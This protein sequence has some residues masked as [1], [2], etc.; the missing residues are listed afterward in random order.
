M[1]RPWRVREPNLTGESLVGQISSSLGNLT[2][3]NTLDLSKNSF[4]GPLPLLKHLQHLEILY[5]QNNLQQGIIPDAL[6]NCSNLA[7]LDL[8][9]NQLTGVIPPSIGFSFFPS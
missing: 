2:D 1:T 8:S 4:A 6:T 5:L 9:R 3:L 7:H